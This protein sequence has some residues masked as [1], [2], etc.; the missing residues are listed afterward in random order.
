MKLI[1]LFIGLVCG[2]TELYLLVLLTR[3]LQQER[4]GR[5]AG[6]IALKFFVLALAF[7]A[8]IL[9]DKNDIL[10]C[11]IGTTLVLVIGA[12]ILSRRLQHAE[13]G[14]VNDK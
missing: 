1:G 9:I 12:F 2:A 6:L 10:W 3:A 13:K 14:D 5:M 4:P 7:L 11:G 8:T